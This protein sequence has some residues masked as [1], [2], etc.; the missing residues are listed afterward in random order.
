M[1]SM[2]VSS[3][4]LKGAGPRRAGRRTGRR[5]ISKIAWRKGE[6]RDLKIRGG[7]HYLVED[8]PDALAELIEKRVSG[9]TTKK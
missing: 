1:A 2:Y 8:Q 9:K 4:T 5:S 6:L 3:P 7:V